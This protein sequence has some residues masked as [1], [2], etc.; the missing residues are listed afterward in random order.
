MFLLYESVTCAVYLQEFIIFTLF[1][2]FHIVAIIHCK[3]IKSI[4]DNLKN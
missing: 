3:I 1:L 2:F 4:D